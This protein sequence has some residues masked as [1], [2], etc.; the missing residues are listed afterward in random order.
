MCTTQ[1]QAKECQ[2]AN[3]HCRQGLRGAGQFGCADTLI[4]RL[5]LPEFGEHWFLVI[6]SRP[7]FGDLLQ[8]P[9]ETNQKVFL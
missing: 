1:P 3:A 9:Y 8:Q 4:L 2:G 7:V 5:W 6:L